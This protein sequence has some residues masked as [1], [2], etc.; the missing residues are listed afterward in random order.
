MAGMA[1]IQIDVGSSDDARGIQR[2]RNLDD[3]AVR[4]TLESAEHGLVWAG[5]DD[6][7]VIG[8]AVAHDSEEERY[9]GDLFV[10]PSYR[11][12]GIGAALLAAAFE[13]SDLS[14]TMIIDTGDAAGLALAL[15]FGVAPRESILQFAGAIPREEELAK[16]AAGD[17][18]F[19]VDTIDAASHRFALEELDHHA[20]GVTRPNDHSAFALQACGHVFFLSGECVGYAY[21]WPDGRIGPVACA[22]EA[23]T[24]QTLAYALV[25][26]SRTYSASWCTLL[27][28]GSNR[29][30]AR[31]ALRAGLRIEQAYTF[32]SETAVGDLSTYVAY[33]RLLM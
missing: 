21:V 18:R 3:V 32:A 8:I 7:A 20:R 23:Y 25:T 29:R 15:R 6:Q 14:R 27:V 26:L 22:S 12:Q 2:R 4:L 28:P 24:V 17:Y 31:A 11:R 19:Q 10:E 5:R 16:M 13:A 1:E 9:I 33:N 30:I